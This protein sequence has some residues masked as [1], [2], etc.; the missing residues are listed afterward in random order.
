MCLLQDQDEQQKRPSDNPSRSVKVFRCQLPRS[1]RFYSYEP[2]KRDGT[3]RP[4][5]IKAALC[6]WCG[7]WKGCSVCG[8]CKRARYCSKKHQAA[9][10]RIG[11]NI[12]CRKLAVDPQHT[13]SSS[14]KSSTETKN[15]K[16]VRTLKQDLTPAVLVYFNSFSFVIIVVIMIIYPY[17]C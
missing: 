15:V 6:S 3:D 14:G 16:K 5:E 17:C 8:N 10:W 2:P 11:H 1:N 9:H 13:N 4:S 7:T 12:E